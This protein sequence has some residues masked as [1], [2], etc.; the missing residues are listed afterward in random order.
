M[1]TRTDEWACDHGCCRVTVDTDFPPD[2]SCDA[3]TPRPMYEVIEDT[4]GFDGREWCWSWRSVTD[5]LSYEETIARD[6][7]RKLRADIEDNP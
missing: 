2:I 6:F 5:N 3:M 7:I 4:S 1:L